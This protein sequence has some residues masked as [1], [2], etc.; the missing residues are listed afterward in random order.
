MAL[1]PLRRAARFPCAEEQP[2]RPSNHFEYSDIIPTRP[3]LLWDYFVGTVGV[4]VELRQG[5]LREPLL[6]GGGDELANV[7]ASNVS[8]RAACDEQRVV[9]CLELGTHDGSH[10]TSSRRGNF[11]LRALIPR[12]SHITQARRK[13]TTCLSVMSS[14]SAIRTIAAFRADR[15]AS[16]VKPRS[17]A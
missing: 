4:P 11:C 3:C 12:R 10:E 16:E 5:I 15:T 7:I 2:D 14:V 17:D 13:V 1:T 8:A 6:C 9:G